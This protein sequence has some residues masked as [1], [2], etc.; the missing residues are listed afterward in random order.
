VE[1]K[2]KESAVEEEGRW[3]RVVVERRAVE[4]ELSSERL[5]DE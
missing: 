2:E 3:M 5:F 4:V 1:R